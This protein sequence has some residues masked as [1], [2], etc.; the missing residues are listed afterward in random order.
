MPKRSDR[1]TVRLK[2][3]S[4]RPSKVELEADMRVD[5]GFEEAVDALAQPTRIRYIDRPKRPE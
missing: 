5:A 3:S 2:P 4:Y 1:P